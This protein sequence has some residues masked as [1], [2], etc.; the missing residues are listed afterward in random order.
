MLGIIKTFAAVA[1]ACPAVAYELPQATY[2]QMVTIQSSQDLRA[3]WKKTLP[4]KLDANHV[5]NFW[6]PVWDEKWNKSVWDSNTRGHFCPKSHKA[7]GQNTMQWDYAFLSNWTLHE[8]IKISFNHPGLLDPRFHEEFP[9]GVKVQNTEVAIMLF[10]AALFNDMNVFLKLVRLEKDLQSFLAIVQLAGLKL[11]E[12]LRPYFGHLNDNFF[13]QFKNLGRQVRDPSTGRFDQDKW[14]TH[15]IQIAVII[16]TEKMNQIPEYKTMLLKTDKKLI[17]EV[18]HNDRNWGIGPKPYKNLIVK[19][20]FLKFQGM[21]KAK[22][23]GKKEKV[24]GKKAR[25]ALRYR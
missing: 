24:N 5:I 3:F 9:Q 18:A 22:V 20:P 15:V 8:K 21:R 25:A 16:L 4:S 12:D 6:L 10:K 14:N 17:V 23:N 2:D 19:F 7:D 1:V 11:N 13:Q